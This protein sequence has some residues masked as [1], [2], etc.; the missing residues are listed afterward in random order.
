MKNRGP[1]RRLVFAILCLLLGGGTALAQVEVDLELV[2]AVDI[3]MSMDPEEQ[4]LQREGYVA[5]LRDPNVMQAI[6]SGHHGRIGVTYFE[7]AGPSSQKILMPWRLIDGPASAEA[8]A[9]EL[10]AQPYSRARMTSISSALLFARQL[11]DNRTFRAPRQV[12][13]VSGDG[14]NNAGPFMS[15]VRP[16]I[17]ASGIVI[18]G[19]P[20]LVRPTLTW[21]PWDAPDL[22]LYYANCVIGGHGAFMI[23][24]RT[25]DEFVAATRHKLLLEIAGKPDEPRLIQAKQEPSPPEYDCSLV[26]QRLQRTP[27]DWP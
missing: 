4:R 2:L 11:F 17:L 18:N 3:S 27:R 21:T 25:T 19:L 13:D 15:V 10:A 23:P 9:T 16:D 14:A 1:M 24:I 6:R 22:D 7:W 12:I 8:F 20:I 26:E 5:A